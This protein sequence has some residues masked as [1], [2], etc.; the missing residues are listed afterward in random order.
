M[1]FDLQVNAGVP[2]GT[3]ISNQ[4]V[5]STDQVP[6]LLTDGDGNPATGPEPTV[7]VVGDGQQLAITKQVAV[8]GGGA[9]LAGSELE[10]VVRVLNIGTVPATLVVITDDLDAPVP[11][12]LAYVP[13]SATLDGAVAGV[14]VLGSVITA[15]YSTLNGPLAP[16]ASTVL[17]FRATLD[18]GLAM[19]TNVTNT[20]VVTWNNPPQMASASV[21]IAV[22]GMPGIGAVN[23]AVWH[24]VNFDDV[25]DPG[26]RELSGWTVSL[27]RNGGLLRSTVTD[28][29][30]TWRIGGLE[31]N[32][33]TSDTYELRFEAPGAGPNTASLGRADSAYTNGPQAI[34]NLIVPAGS[35]L[36]DLNLP[37]DPNGV[38][39]GSLE[40]DPVAGAQL[41]MLDGPGGTPLPTACFDDPVQQGQVTRSDGFYKFDL[42]FSDAACPS[43]GS[44]VI[45]VD[46]GSAWASGPSQVIPP[47]SDASTPPFSVPA[48]SGSA[49]D[50]VPAPPGFCEVQPS[51]LAPPPS[52]PPRSAGT[53]HHLHLVLDAS[54]APGSS[55]IFNNHIAVDPVLGG[56]LGITKT[57]PSLTVSRGELVPYEITVRNDLA[58]PL[59][60]LTLVDRYPAGF[61]YVKGSARVDGV[62]IEPTVAGRELTWTDLGVDAG[63]S[64]NV[65]LLLA[66][67]AGVGDG[68]FVNR[69]QAVSSLTG[70]ALSGEATASVRVVP[71]PDFACTDVTG[72][73]FDDANRNGVQDPGE[74]GLAGVRLVTLRGLVA[75]TDA[76]GR[77][78]ITCAMSPNEGRGSNFVLKLDE[79]TLPS[80]FR[81]ATRQTQV[82]RATRGKA[83]R[84]NYAAS[85]HRVVALDMADAVF[86]PGSTE[87]RAQWEP[88][89]ERLLEELARAPSTLRLSYVADVEDE[90][91]VERRL[92]AVKDR[93][94]KAWKERG[95]DYPLTIEPEVFWRRGGPPEQPTAKAGGRP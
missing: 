8:V 88:R 23:G 15:D 26:E 52:V 55:Q 40:R 65:V 91:L 43:G 3:L 41:T 79:R 77:Y 70:L 85:I 48:C 74:A 83:L 28:A 86:E 38:V 71:D 82:Q 44:Y 13:G 49:S 60:D 58:V 9:A 24:D 35:N 37:I 5:V 31:P 11:G 80:G 69:A 21:S 76:H 54:Q 6:T 81:M 51:E 34:S 10:Y 1:E 78:H 68:K 89:L 27:Y 75:T 16:G 64:R 17:R 30:G 47:L 29:A 90:K 7:V 36:Q 42:N 61:R 62:A 57:T 67:G 19:G 32:A 72:K 93:I 73:V 94:S 59:P 63:S 50:V 95:G 56:V 53:N 66:V 84:L 92:E 18:A 20:G 12:Q 2:P 22:G 46:A 25:L 87:M 33:G 39:Y 4:A 45:E 14:S